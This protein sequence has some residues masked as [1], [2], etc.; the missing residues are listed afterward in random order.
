MK[1]V[2]KA[3]LIKISNTRSGILKA[4]KYISSSSLVKKPA[5]ILY[6][7]NP[8]I[9]DKSIMPERIIVEVKMLV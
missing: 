5:N 3:P 7:I 2:L 8:A 9:L 4:A 6:L 1:V